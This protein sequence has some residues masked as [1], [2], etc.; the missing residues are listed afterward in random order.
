MNWIILCLIFSIN[1]HIYAQSPFLSGDCE[2][3]IGR[4]KTSG[5]D[6]Y[7]GSFKDGLFEERGKVK[8]KDGS[9]IDGD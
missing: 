8:L 2:N 5:G 7:E 3:G 4:Y 9:N 6:L 1:L